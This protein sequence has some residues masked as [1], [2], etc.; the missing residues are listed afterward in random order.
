M[1]SKKSAH[2][3]APVPVEVVRGNGRVKQKL[4]PEFVGLASGQEDRPRPIRKARP[5]RLDDPRPVA[6]VSGVANR[7]ARAVYEKRVEALAEALQALEGRLPADGDSQTG[8]DPEVL[9]ALTL[10]GEFAQRRL[11]RARH[12]ASLAVF[13]EEG[14]QLPSESSVQWMRACALWQKQAG[15]EMSEEAVAVCLRAE[16]ALLE[17]G[18]EATVSTFRVENGERLRVEVALATAPAAMEALHRRW[19][20]L[21][22]DGFGRRPPPRKAPRKR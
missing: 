10:L 7:D 14:L 5:P 8:K 13:L 3:K 1:P 18:V 17:A 9:R 20:S 2:L 19:R 11:W 4:A 22:T 15:A 6:M 12:W 21:L 16:A